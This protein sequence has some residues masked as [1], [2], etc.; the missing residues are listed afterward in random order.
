MRI[1]KPPFEHMFASRNESHEKL[2]E[3]FIL[4]NLFAFEDL[5]ENLDWLHSC[6]NTKKRISKN[7]PCRKHDLWIFFT[8][9]QQICKGQVKRVRSY[10][11]KVGHPQ[12][13]RS[14]ET[15]RQFACIPNIV[16][17]YNLTMSFSYQFFFVTW[18]H[19]FVTILS[20]A[21]L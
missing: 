15:T 12:S 20:C 2:D 18:R 9:S 1:I 17:E 19:H 14:R 5:W 6:R 7:R 3:I 16:R 21:W 10:G 8:R 4:F 11:M 13:G